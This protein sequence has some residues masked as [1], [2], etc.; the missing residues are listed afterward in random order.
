MKRILGLFLLMVALS[1]C[2]TDNYGGIPVVA[3]NFSVDVYSVDQGELGNIP[4]NYAFYREG[5]RGVMVYCT[6][7]EQYV[8]YERTCTYRP[9]TTCVS[10]LDVDPSGSFLYCP[11]CGSEFMIFSGGVPTKGSKAHKRLL[12]YN[13]S[14]NAMTHTVFIYN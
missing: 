6:F 14:Y 1:S 2:E 10:K 4:G 12:T 9:E 11:D 13:T 5:W 8:A 7:V 3:V